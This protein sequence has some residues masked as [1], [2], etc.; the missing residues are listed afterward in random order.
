M[1]V[2]QAANEVSAHVSETARHVGETASEY[3]AQGREKVGE[4]EQYLEDNIRAKPLQSLMIAAGVG[5]LLGL[6]YKR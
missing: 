1:P 3:Y 2:R 6:L 5:V 4:M